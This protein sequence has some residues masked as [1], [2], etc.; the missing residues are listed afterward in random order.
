[1]LVKAL[2]GA[3]ARNYTGAGNWGVLIDGLPRTL[4]LLYGLHS[5]PPDEFD[6]VA[7]KTLVTGTPLVRYPQPPEVPFAVILDPPEAMNQASSVFLADPAKNVILPR[8]D[9]AEQW[10][11]W[12]QARMG[13][14][15][16]RAIFN[17]SGTPYDSTKET[18]FD[19]SEMRL[20][21]VIV[22]R[23]IG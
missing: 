20:Q 18:S 8:N 4:K 9:K 3:G 17:G 15:S 10:I 23:V 22:H 11:G 14:C 16:V 13:L 19:L 6:P 7:I 2:N 21:P 1:V 12:A 5:W